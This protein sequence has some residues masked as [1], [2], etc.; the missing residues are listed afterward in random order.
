MR[1]LTTLISP[2]YILLALAVVVIVVAD[3]FPSD[4]NVYVCSVKT[5]KDGYSSSCLLSATEVHIW[6]LF[7]WVSIGMC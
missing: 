7:P 4:L 6:D 5:V 1:T 3:L 2:T